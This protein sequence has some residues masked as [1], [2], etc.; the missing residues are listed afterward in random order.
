MNWEDLSYENEARDQKFDTLKAY[1]QSKLCNILFTRELARRLENSS[2][3]V[4]ALHPGVVLTELGRYMG[5]VFGWRISFLMRLLYPI[6]LFTLKSP[7]YGAQTTNYCAVAPELSSASG[8]Y[9]SDCKEKRIL[10]HGAD[11][12]DATKLW[13]ISQQLSGVLD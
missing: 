7:W 2:V 1:R 11:A 13:E 3:T 9:F 6:I 10:P 8:C 5:D 4:N 12:Q